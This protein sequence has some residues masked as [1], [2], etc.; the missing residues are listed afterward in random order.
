MQDKKLSHFHNISM[1]Y[2]TFMSVK[3]MFMISCLFILTLFY[4]KHKEFIDW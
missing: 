4:I 2:E 3:K 1:F